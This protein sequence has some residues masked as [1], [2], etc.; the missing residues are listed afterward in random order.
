MWYFQPLGN[1]YR[2]LHN[3]LLLLLLGA[4]VLSTPLVQAQLTSP[5]LGDGPWEIQTYQAKIK[6]SVV[7]RGM[8]HP[9]SMEFLPGGDILV[10]ERSGNLR[11]IRDGMLD[12]NPIPGV[13]TVHAVRLS[14][15]ME[16]LLHPQFEENQLVY[17]TYTKRIKEEPLEVATT[18]AR[19]RFN[20]EALVDVEEILV[21]DTWAGNG[22]SGARILFGPDGK[23][24]MTTGASNGNAAQEGNNLRG[25]ILRLNDDGTAP[26]DNP[27][28]GKEGYRPEIYSMGHR[29]SLGLAFH[30]VTGELW[31]S[32]YGPNGGDEVNIIKPGANYGWP[33]V[34]YGRDYPGPFISTSPFME[35]MEVPVSTF[36]PGI[37]PSG[38]AFYTG[39][40]FPT[41]TTSAFV[42]ANRV[43]QV[44][45]TG[46]LV[47]IFYDENGNERHREMLLYREISQRIRDIQMGPDGK[48]YLLTEE[49]DGALLRID[50]VEQ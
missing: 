40:D 16:I 23:L 25:K 9:W 17:L 39:T 26:S 8:S 19:G 34:S 24:Y 46:H 42:G 28:V 3:R 20:G 12:P 10:T 43:G 1:R 45:G 32:E 35:G 21:A 11:I 41:W 2:F 49:E 15:L 37:S 4:A 44:P 38:L 27:F 36:I 50:P 33:L 14:G 29:N 48:M 47:R 6:V 18:L 13:P 31:N 22:G 7:A 30:P 5:P